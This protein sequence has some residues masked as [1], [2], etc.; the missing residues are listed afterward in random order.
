MTATDVTDDE[1]TVEEAALRE[2]LLGLA[3]DDFALGHRLTDWV[4]LGPTM[5]EDNTLASIAQDELGHARLWYEALADRGLVE[6][7][8]DDLALNRR[9]AARRNSTLV[10]VDHDD[11]ADVVAISLL[12]H[13][14]ERRL[15]EAVADGDDADLAGRSRQAL[16]E[17]PFHR[18]HADLWS[19]RL[20]ATDE[21]RSR[22][23]A[24]LAAALPRTTDLFAFPERV[25]D[26]LVEAGT[27][28]VDPAALRAEWAA[29]V[30]DRLHALD[31]SVGDE[32]LGALD[33]VDAAPERNGR[34]GEHTGALADLVDQIHA[35]DDVLV[36]DHPVLRPRADGGERP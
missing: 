8:L 32:A 6:G 1:P 29:D 24:A 15:L 16:D 10:E 12:Y 28:A 20:T 27:L 30:R 21:A 14:A 11:Y 19:E 23:E 36:G 7:D 34:V 2:F 26:P 35:G 18:E 3:D 22:L 33:A 5:E 17:E 31:L 9:P 25:A 13:D 4:G